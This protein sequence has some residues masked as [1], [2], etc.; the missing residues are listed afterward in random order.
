M[1]IVVPKALDE[2]KAETFAAPVATAL[3]GSAFTPVT[4]QNGWAGE[5]SGYMPVSYLKMG[6][7][8][9]V[10]GSMQHPNAD[11]VSFFVAWTLPAGYRPAQTMRCFGQGFKTAVGGL[12]AWRGDLSVGGGFAPGEFTP[13]TTPQAMTI[14]CNFCFWAG[15]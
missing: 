7:L 10:Q 14:S 3:N 4:F 1:A 9:I 2:M 12:Y 15:F 13:G 11:T 6:G 8:V 5:G